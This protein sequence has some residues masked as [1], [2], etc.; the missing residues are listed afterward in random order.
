MSKK[1][2]RKIEVK[3]HNMIS[4]VMSY[5]NRLDLLRHTLF[6][7]CNSKVKN[8]EIIIVDDYSDSDH[9]PIGLIDE[10]KDIKIKIFHMRNYREKGTYNNPCI[11]YNIGFSHSAGDKII[12]QNPECC[13][14]GDVLNYVENNLND[15]NYL[16][17]HCYAVNKQDLEKIHNNEKIIYNNVGKGKPEISRWYNHKKYRPVGYHFTSAITR[18]NLSDLNGFDEQFS[19][20]PNYDDDEFIYR[21]GL[22]NLIVDFVESPFV[23][24]QYHQSG[25]GHGLIGKEGNRSNRPLLKRLHKEKNIRVNITK[26][27]IKRKANEIS[28]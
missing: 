12:I 15:N 9:D 6:T 16:S 21:V 23:I 3:G 14:V 17:F 24:H 11:P 5:Y 25:G 26:Q 20:A 18:K 8:F 7:I 28:F 10:F 4:I 13:H 19:Q 2:K 22:K 27:I 1:E